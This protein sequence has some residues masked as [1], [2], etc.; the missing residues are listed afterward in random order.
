MDLYEQLPV[1]SNNAINII[2]FK[3]CGQLANERAMHL[4]KKLLNRVSNKLANDIVIASSAVHMLM[5][6]GDVQ[7]AEHLFHSI[8]HKNVLSYGVMMQGK[9]SS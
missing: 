5:R 6:F 2:T 1:S 7:D 8:K 4:G 3:A 9:H